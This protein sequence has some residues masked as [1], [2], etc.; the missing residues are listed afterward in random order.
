M[1]GD[2]QEGLAIDAKGD[3]WVADDK[4]KSLLRLPDGLRALEGHVKGSAAPGPS[5]QAAPPPGAAA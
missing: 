4:D 2:Q 1:P 3:I 5:S